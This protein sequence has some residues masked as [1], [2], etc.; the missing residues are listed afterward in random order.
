MCLCQACFDSP[1]FK[2]MLARR[3][4]HSH[5]IPAKSSS[6][7]TVQSRFNPAL[8][9]H[10]LPFFA[11]AY[12]R[13]ANPL[14]PAL[15]NHDPGTTRC[16]TYKITILQLRKLHRTHVLAYI[17]VICH[18]ACA[19]GCALLILLADCPRYEGQGTRARGTGSIILAEGMVILQMTRIVQEGKRG[20]G[21]D[22]EHT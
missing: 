5:E 8:Q 21:G 12:Q 22:W 7:C 19:V 4:A 11:C 17:V 1:Y 18:Y 13:S 6:L 9:S 2:T 10:Y 16:E 14:T 15:Y 3:N 20:E